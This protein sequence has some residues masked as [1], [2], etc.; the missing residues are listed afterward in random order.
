MDEYLDR[1]ETLEIQ[2][3]DEVMKKQ[4][5]LAPRVCSALRGEAY[6]AAKAAKIKKIDLAQNEGVELLSAAVKS[7][8]RGSGPTRVGEIFDKYVDDDARRPG[9]AI[10][11]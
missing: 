7:A 11:V 4:G 2:Y 8:I 1:V 10:R 5:P 3:T 6:T 9:T